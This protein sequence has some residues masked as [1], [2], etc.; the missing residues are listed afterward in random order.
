MVR[1]YR[2]DIGLEIGVVNDNPEALKK[3][4]KNYWFAGCKI[5]EQTIPL[6]DYLKNVTLLGKPK[7]IECDWKKNKIMRIEY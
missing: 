3:I 2:H 5:I 1:I 4:S 7:W 6:N